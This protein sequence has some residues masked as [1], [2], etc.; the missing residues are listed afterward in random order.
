MKEVPARVHVL[1]ARTAPKAVLIVQKRSKLFH[2]VSWEYMADALQEGS[3]FNGKIYS[4]RCDL[5]RD[6]RHM[7]YFALGPT[8]EMFSWSAVCEPPFLKASMLWEHDDTWFGGGVFLGGGSLYMYLDEGTP[9]RNEMKHVP[10]KNIEKL[11]KIHYINGDTIG[12]SIFQ[13]KLDKDGWKEKELTPTRKLYE[14]ESLDGNSKLMLSCN[15]SWETEE[16]HYDLLDTETGDPVE[17]SPV[18]GKT[19][20]ADWDASGCL[21]TVKDG[22]VTCHDAVYDYDVFAEVNCNQFR[23][24]GSSD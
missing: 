24:P 8:K 13:V 3:W 4:R 18:D 6:G 2:V 16:W 22:I 20:W 15:G 23:K 21:I 1:L 12:S 17:N 19:T 9:R 5:S 7:L 11:Y 10:S 14:K